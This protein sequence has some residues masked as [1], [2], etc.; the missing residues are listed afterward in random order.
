MPR[1]LVK[2]VRDCSPLSVVEIQTA[3]RLGRLRLITPQH[4][5]RRASDPHE[6]VFEED[7]VLLDDNLLG[8]PSKHF[9][10]LLN[11]PVATTS[12]TLDPRNKRD[13]RPYLEQMPPG[14]FPVGR[15]DRD[16][17]G[18]LLFT[19]DGDLASAV[20]R[21]EHSTDK[22]YWLWLN[23]QFED[24]DERLELLTRTDDPRYR[25]AKSAQVLRRTDHYVELL[26]T[27]NEGKNRQIR[28]MCRALNL[29]LLHLHRKR[30]GVLTDQNLAVGEVREL[31][32]AQAQALWASV[33]GKAGV[34]ARQFEALANTSQSLL[35]SGEGNDR[36]Q[37]WLARHTQTST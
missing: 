13:L 24:D 28:R 30:L 23:E 35:E 27:L 31:D 9:H 6:F 22:L 18:L 37:Q 29:R 5:E 3:V 33:G 21:P 17:T 10:A 15:L 2:F 11:K 8:A 32:A 20:L 4:G 16:T 25:G 34:L 14:V 7:R 19:S 26:V 12:T 36:L 1:R